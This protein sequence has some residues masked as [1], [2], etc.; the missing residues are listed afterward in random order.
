MDFVSYK[1][2]KKAILDLS[3]EKVII[4]LENNSSLNNHDWPKNAS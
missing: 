1:Q 4:R 2:G 3:E